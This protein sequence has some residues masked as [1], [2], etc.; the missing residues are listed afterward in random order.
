[1]KKILLIFAFLFLGIGFANANENVYQD[2]GYESEISIE[3]AI[4]FNHQYIVSENVDQSIELEN[5]YKYIVFDN[6]SKIPIEIT[7]LFISGF[8]IEL[9]DIKHQNHN[10][11]N[12]QSSLQ[13]NNKN[14]NARDCL[15]CNYKLIA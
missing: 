10:L 6:E 7:L 15:W 4:D 8:D 14:K 3:N 13:P 11:L 9:L 5:H 1:M 2:V 12:L